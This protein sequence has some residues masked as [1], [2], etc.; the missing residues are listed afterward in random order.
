MKI[1]AII[2]S[3]RKG[4][5][6]KLT[7]KIEK[8][9]QHHE[10]IE[11]IYVFLREYNLGNC[12]GCHACVNLGKEKCPLNDDREIIE[13]KMLGADGVIF[14]SPIYN[15]H[16][17]ALMKNF[18]DHFTYAV[19]R[20]PFFGKKAMIFIQRGE[21]FKDAVK[22]MKKIIHAWGF[23]VVSTLGIPDLDSLTNTYRK[24]S[25]KKLNKA[26]DRF[27]EGLNKKRLPSPSIYDLVW[28]NIWKINV[29]ATKDGIP[30]DYTYWAAKGWLDMNYYYTIKINPF[31][32]G[33]ASIGTF[34]A[35][36]FMKRIFKGY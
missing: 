3:P 31:K 27:Y 24:K 28:F 34:V 36:K 11:F 18:V 6:Y 12:T 32:K 13:K 30:A 25:I 7:Q 33:I 20:P 5:S 2:G 4:N 29:E 14:V 35:K 21:L 15:L 1:L 23:E 8:R 22:Y 10:H 9:L 26:T 19:H 16:I 17:T